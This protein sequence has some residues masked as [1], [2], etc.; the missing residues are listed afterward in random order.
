MI[1]TNTDILKGINNKDIIIS[2][3]IKDNLGTNSYDVTLNSKLSVYTSEYLDVRKN[4]KS[5]TIEIPECGFMLKPNTLYLGQTNETATSNKY[6]PVYEGRSSMGRLGI[7]SHI[8][9]GFRDIGFGFDP[10]NKNDCYYS[11]WTLEIVVVQKTIIYP[12]I[13]IGQVFFLE[14]KS[15]PYSLYNGKYSIQKLPTTSLS[16][17]DREVP[18]NSEKH[19][20][21]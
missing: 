6:V 9:A 12:N 5:K 8:T 13:R 17:M 1:L 3:F 15:A 11:T 7:F 14:P 16:Y 4:N 10:L 20:G 18:I 19:K 2:P 21:I